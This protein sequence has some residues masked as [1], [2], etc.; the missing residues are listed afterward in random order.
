V[1]EDDDFIGQ[2][3]C[4][5]NQAT[6]CASVEDTHININQKSAEE[7]TMRLL[8]LVTQADGG[9]SFLQEVLQ[10]QSSVH[11]AQQRVAKALRE[12]GVEIVRASVDNVP[13]LN[14]PTGWLCAVPKYSDGNVCDCDCG[15]WDPDCDLVT[16]RLRVV[17][18]WD[19]DA[20][21]LRL[22]DAMQVF[23][24]MKQTDGK[25]NGNGFID[26]RRLPR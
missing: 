11:R 1:E 21:D 14:L 7:R 12:Q 22:L 18:I 19:G 17:A 5:Q 16:E 15:I 20:E 4:S 24:V 26:G 8:G 25:L 3:K 23:E 2:E 13:R 9:A 6:I 10:S